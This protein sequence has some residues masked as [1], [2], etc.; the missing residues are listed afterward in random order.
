MGQRDDGAAEGLRILDV[1]NVGDFV[2]KGFAVTPGEASSVCASGDYAYVADGSA[3][4]QIVDIAARSDSGIFTPRIVGTLDTGGTAL[5]VVVSGDYAD[6]ADGDQGLR[7][8]DVTDPAAPSPVAAWST[9]TTGTALKV[10]SVGDYAF[11][12]EDRA[13]TAV[14]KLSDETPFTPEPFNPPGTSGSCFIDLLNPYR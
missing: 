11:V 9:T 12:A 3:G 2:F 1:L 14:Y 7:I 10:V 13:G 6:V 4:L 8:V 5:D